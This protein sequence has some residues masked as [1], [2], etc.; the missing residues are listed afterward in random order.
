MPRGAM[1]LMARLLGSN[2]HFAR[3]VPVQPPPHK[4]SDL[5]ENAVDM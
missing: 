4:E 3:A 1:T 5:F 2:E